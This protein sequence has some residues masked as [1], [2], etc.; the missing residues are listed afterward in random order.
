MKTIDA[1]IDIATA[2]HE[3]WRVLTRFSDYGQ[4]NPFITRID[5]TPGLGE[6]ITVHIATGAG[7]S[8]PVEAEIV[9]FKPDE[10]L[11]W[12]SKLLAKGVFDR[13]HSI[14]LAANATGCIV[15][16]TQT[17]EGPLAPA[18]AALTEGV[19]RHGLSRMNDALKRRVEQVGNN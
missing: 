6:T 4:W 3:I 19:V 11:V 18:A 17:F 14:K 12:R 16:Q 1:E 2:P 15:W 5:G 7:V 10:E 13:D 8:L 9:T